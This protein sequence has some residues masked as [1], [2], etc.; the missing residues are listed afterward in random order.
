MARAYLRLDPGFFEKKVLSQ[1]Y[2]AG[3]A[4]A[5]IGVLCLAEHQ[6]DR[7][8]FR[9]ERV[10]RALLD[11]YGRWIPYLKEH[12]DLV[13]ESDGRLYPPG[14]SEWQEGDHTV[15][16]RVRRIRARARDTAPTVT[17]ATP[18]TVT[19]DTGP[20]VTPDTPAT[21]YTPSERSVIDG[22]G[23]A[24][25]V[26]P[27]VRPRRARPSGTNGTNGLTLS[28]DE[29]R[30]WRTF[31]AD[32]WGP[33]RRAWHGRHFRKPPSGDSEDR[34]T[35]RGVLWE[36]A[37]DRPNDLGGWV[38]EAPGKSAREVVGYVLD[39]WHEIQAAAAM[40]EA[41]PT[42]GRAGP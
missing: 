28:I 42:A 7:G 2:P 34:T 14:W 17:D 23:K 11:T 33:F 6:P 3:A 35:Q 30:A 29:L 20:P 22:G 27:V 37:R 9:N 32:E 25:S 10:L 16:E 31:E 39:R 13:V 4:I 36:I 19:S 18:P 40:A 15:A 41:R 8:R 12:G 1:G 38:A 5:L 24:L 21:V 26:V